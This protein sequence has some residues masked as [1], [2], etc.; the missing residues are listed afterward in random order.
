MTTSCREYGERKG[1]LVECSGDEVPQVVR[2][3]RD[4]GARDGYRVVS[5]EEAPDGAGNAQWVEDHFSLFGEPGPADRAP[6][7]EL[8]ADARRHFGLPADAP[9]RDC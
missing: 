7:T 1:A 9:V 8:E 4:P 3:A 6:S 5:R 2:L